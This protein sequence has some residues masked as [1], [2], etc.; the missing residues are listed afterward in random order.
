MSH[1]INETD[2]EWAERSVNALAASL[3]VPE[4]PKYGERLGS[5][6]PASGRSRSR[7]PLLIAAT[8]AVV[9]LLGAGVVITRIGSDS[10]AVDVAGDQSQPTSTLSPDDLF[11]QDA[12]NLT[13]PSFPPDVQKAIYEAQLAW[14]DCMHAQGISS[15][16]S[17]DPNF[18]DGKTPPMVVGGA[19]G[20]PAAE[21]QTG[22]RFDAAWATCQPE[23]DAVGQAGASL[24][25]D[26][27]PGN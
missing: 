17:P 12:A 24:H 5:Y 7:R 27:K 20:S 11:T 21:D 18:G 10:K 2:H 1:N 16:P 6:P 25:P 14:S 19:A 4:R 23:L 22:P 13:K 15:F 3:H 8:C 26:L 9:A